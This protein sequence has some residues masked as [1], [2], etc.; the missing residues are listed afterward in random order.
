MSSTRTPWLPR[1]PV[2]TSRS[3]DP[4]YAGPVLDMNEEEPRYA[5]LVAVLSEV[6]VMTTLQQYHAVVV[7]PDW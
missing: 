2:P 3:P 7:K 4:V 5:C 6:A 1:L